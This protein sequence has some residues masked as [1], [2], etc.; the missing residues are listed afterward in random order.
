[1]KPI[2][3]AIWLILCV[4]A[5]GIL[6]PLQDTMPWYER[7][8]ICTFVFVSMFGIGVGLKMED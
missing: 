7:A 1:M 6:Y 4:I 2:L 8:V 3:A 5:I